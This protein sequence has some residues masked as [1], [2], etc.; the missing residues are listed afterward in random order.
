MK[1]PS[2]FVLNTLGSGLLVVIP[3]YL[4]VLLILKAAASVAGLVRP[5]SKLVP[6]WVPAERI[7]SLFL[8]LMICFLIGVAVR[9]HRGRMARDVI[10]KALFERIPGYATIRSLTHRMAGDE[11]ERVWRPAFAEIEEALVPAFIIEE[12]EDGRYTVFVPSVP[13]P[14]AGAVYILEGKRV[15]PLEVP[16]TQA[17][18]VISKWGSGAKDLVT[19]AEKHRSQ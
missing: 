1:K 3:I 13:T 8:V 11:N 10:E 5:L 19:S 18:R 2:Q 16:L 17:L 14:F 4:A 9:T 12:F 15:H 6:D 7:L